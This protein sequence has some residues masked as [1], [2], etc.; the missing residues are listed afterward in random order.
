LEN[1]KE[2][3]GMYFRLTQV[4]VQE[5]KL[6]DAIAYAGDVTDSFRDTPGLF[7]ICIAEMD[8][9][10]MTS[11]SLWASENA[12]NAAGPKIQ[13]ALSGLG[14]F[15]SGP[16]T[17]SHGPMNVGQMYRTVK[18]EETD[19]FVVRLGFGAE[20]IEEK[21]DE[22]NDWIQNTVYAGYEGTEGLIGGLGAS[23]DGKVVTLSN[24]ESKEALDASQ[25]K[26]QEI[27]ADAMNYI[28]NPPTIVTGVCNLYIANVTFPEGKLSEWNK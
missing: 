26:F 24:W 5:G 23:V 18:K 12:M 27:M 2:R 22:A 19:P 9:G 20:Y 16:P 8:N 11:W 3:R 1:Y 7:Q 13:E 6:N 21:F 10:Q 15:V 28:K 17:I 25:E 4:D 14:E